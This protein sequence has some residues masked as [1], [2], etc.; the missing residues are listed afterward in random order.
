MS[1]TASIDTPSQPAVV[2]KFGGTSVR[3]AAAMRRVIEI[4]ER[5][6]GRRPVVITSACAGVTDVLLACARACGENR[7]D[8]ALAFV[9]RLRETHTEIHRDLVPDDGACL[10]DLTRL[11]DEIEALVRGVVLLGELTP[12]TTDLFASFGERLSSILL[13]A[14]FRTSGWRAALADSRDVIITDAQF[15]SARPLMHLID[16]RAGSVLLPMFAEH[17]VIVAQGFIGSTA[18]GVTTTLGRGGSDFTGALMGAGLRARE[19]QIWT[20]VSGI[21]T[22]DPRVV[23]EAQVVAEVTFTEARE[24]AY[25]GAKVIHPDTILPAVERAIPVVVKN[26]MRPD[27][28]GTRILPDGSPVRPGVHSITVK[29]GT[30]ALRL[31]PR[32]P[33]AGAAPAERALALFAEHGIELYCAM[34]AESRALAVVQGSAL[35]DIF[36]ADLESSC[37][38]EIDRD[39]ALLCLTGASLRSTPAVLAEPLA[40]LAGIA[41]HF[42]SAGTS[43]NL[44]LVG[45]QEADAAPALAAVHRR[46]F[47]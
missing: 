14:A 27:D 40:A 45:V 31:S 34:L 17:E 39:I 15:M 35:H 28:A 23:P 8:D 2:M 11:L 42:V 38:V 36:L 43:D 47:E 9:A 29:R 20:D 18:Q 3:D 25:F 1:N 5:E 10:Q 24:L 46:L 37:S 26:S 21:L 13:A 12:R 44:I 7:L 6:R 41:V 4:V 19:I 22:A 30:A 16:E 33:A 32:D